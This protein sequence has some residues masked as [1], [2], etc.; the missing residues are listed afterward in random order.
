MSRSRIR[1]NL[2]G[3]RRP[4]TAVYGELR[5]PGCVVQPLPPVGS[6]VR[7]YETVYLDRDKLFEGIY[8]REHTVPAGGCRTEGGRECFWQVMGYTMGIENPKK[9]NNH[10][11]LKCINPELRVHHTTT[12][13]CVQISY[14]VLKVRVDGH[15]EEDGTYVCTSNALYDY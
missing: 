15:V 6:I 1:K 4:C 10:M 9:A 3:Y 8:G 2:A 12:F 11:I 13:S 14:G 7:L 5:E